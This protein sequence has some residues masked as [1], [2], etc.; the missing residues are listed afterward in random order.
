MRL[1]EA[2][3]AARD[4]LAVLA[5]V[6]PQ[7]QLQCLALLATC[8]LAR[9]DLD[10]AGQHLRRCETLLQAGNYHSDWLV[11]TDKARVIYWQITGDRQ[12][13]SRWLLQ[14][15]RPAEPDNHFYRGS[16]AISR[17]FRSCWGS[18]MRHRWCWSS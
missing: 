7:Q 5:N 16:G 15:V 6:E 14:A 11:N 3:R 17:G 8:S 9:G 1:D 13:A 4:G 2:E 12:A 18:M 10:N